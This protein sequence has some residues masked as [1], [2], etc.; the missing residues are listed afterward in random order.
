VLLKVDV[1]DGRYLGCWSSGGAYKLLEP[2]CLPHFWSSVPRERSVPM[3]RRLLSQYPTYSTLHR[4][5]CDSVKSVPYQ[6]DENSLEADIPFVQLMVLLYGFTQKDT[7]VSHAA[8]DMEVV[9]GGQFPNAARDPI[10]ALSWYSPGHEEVL[11]GG[12]AGIIEGFSDLMCKGNP[13]SC[14][15]YN[16]N[17]FDW[18][19]LI[20]RAAVLKAKLPVGRRRDPPW[21][22][23]FERRFGKMKGI[24]YEINLTGRVNFDVW[25]E[26]R[27][28][29]SLTGEIK[30]RQLK[31][32]ARYFFPDEDF[33]EVDRA[34]LGRLSPGELRD[35]CLSDARA[36]YKLADSYLSLL[37]LPTVELHCP[38]DLI[39]RRTPS[40]IGNYLYG[41]EFK[42]LDVVSDG[43]NLERF[44]YLWEGSK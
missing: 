22:Q 7:Q 31:T 8:W 33:V 17:R 6:R 18:R 23:Q 38:L 35:Y 15:T 28:D 41:S 24:D 20:Q 42:R 37:M 13:D 21:V 29:T 44:D 16:G 32:V 40:H 5:D 30:N 19:Y 4:V 10:S 14:D 25:R 12:E 36:T 26:V 2:P 3:R 1:V 43:P 11:T 34:H 27:Y 9:G 39:V